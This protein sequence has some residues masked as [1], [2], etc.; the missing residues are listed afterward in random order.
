MM[1]GRIEV[2]SELG[3]GSTFGFSA[4]FPHADVAGNNRD[5]A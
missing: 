4:S 2:R 5:A 3:V 1:G